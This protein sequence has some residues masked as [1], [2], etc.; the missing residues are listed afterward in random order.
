MTSHVTGGSCIGQEMT[1]RTV[2]PKVI[3]S[4]DKKYFI[5]RWFFFCP[6]RPEM[7]NVVEFRESNKMEADEA[8]FLLQIFNI[9]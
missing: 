6:K 8:S 9:M 4:I 1:F 5:G 7:T 3:P 2:S